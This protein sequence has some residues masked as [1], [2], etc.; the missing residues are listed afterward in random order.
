MAGTLHQRYLADVFA[1]ATRRV[2]DRQEVKYVTVEVFAAAFV[3][4]PHKKAL[5]DP[6]P[7]LLGIASIEATMKGLG[8]TP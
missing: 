3:A 8:M 2:P 7:S 1:Y 6:Y 5:S 4:L